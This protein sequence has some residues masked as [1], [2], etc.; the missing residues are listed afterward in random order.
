MPPKS[1]NW[2][3]Q[4]CLAR[5]IRAIANVL[6]VRARRFDY[7]GFIEITRQLKQGRSPAQQQAIVAKVFD[8]LIP[9]TVSALIRRFVRPTRWVCEGNAWFATR[10]TGWL[11]GAS[12]R[13]WVE[14]LLPNKSRQWQQSGVRIQKCRYLAE[15]QC[16]A[17]CVNL[18]KKPTEQFFRQQLG[19]PLT[20]TP[21]FRDSSC[22]MVFGTPAHPI[23]E[24]TI[25]P[26]WH[27]PTQASC[28]HV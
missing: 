16:M 27:E 17:L 4:W 28:P 8:L 7:V 21:N 24:P 26:C 9:P 5:L 19:L 14:V 3:E 15:G 25:L 13:Y 1:L 23:P 18:C 22:E 10:L 2:L 12:D 20:M 6:G 11:V